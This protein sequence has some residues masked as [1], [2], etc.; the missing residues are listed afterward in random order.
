MP[1]IFNMQVYNLIDKWYTEKEAKQI[2]FKSQQS[3]NRLDWNSYRE[4]EEAK[5]YASLTSEERSILRK[6]K[7]TGKPSYM[8]KIQWWKVVLKNK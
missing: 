2:A 3:N 5:Q 8:Y 4:T 7:Q 1:S 6:S